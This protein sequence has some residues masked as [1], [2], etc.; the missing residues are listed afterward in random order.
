MKAGKSAL[1]F[2]ML[3]VL[4][5]KSAPVNPDSAPPE[6]IICRAGPKGVRN[7]TPHERRV[8]IIVDGQYP[9]RDQLSS[10]LSRVLMRA[11][12]TVLGSDQ[13]EGFSDL[14]KFLLGDVFDPETATLAIGRWRDAHLFVIAEIRI[15]GSDFR[16]WDQERDFWES[17]HSYIRCL[18]YNENTKLWEVFVSGCKAQRQMTKQD[19]ALELTEM[20]MAKL[21]RMLDH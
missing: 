12:Y 11:G 14:A 13:V 8:M 17:D 9:Y 18:D 6:E 2:L 1:F 3:L 5:C 19:F 7:E 10:H 16:I 21:E 20:L 4:G 15:C